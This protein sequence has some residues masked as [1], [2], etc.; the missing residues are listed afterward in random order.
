MSVVIKSHLRHR[1]LQKLYPAIAQNFKKQ[2]GFLSGG[3]QQ[4][5]AICR[6]LMANPKLYYLMNHLLG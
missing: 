2:A 3:E 1:V 5:P 6:A 4:I